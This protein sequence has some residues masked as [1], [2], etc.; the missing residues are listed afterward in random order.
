MENIIKMEKNIN[1]MMKKLILEKIDFIF[2]FEGTDGLK[3]CLKGLEMVTGFKHGSCIDFDNFK[4]YVLT[5]KFDLK[6]FLEFYSNTVS[7]IDE[8]MFLGFEDSCYV[9]EE[10]KFYDEVCEAIKGYD[11]DKVQLNNYD[12]ILDDVLDIILE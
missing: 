6:N 1:D 7:D 11:W 10:N 9:V 3:K 2:D 8:L 4:K 5:S 12:E